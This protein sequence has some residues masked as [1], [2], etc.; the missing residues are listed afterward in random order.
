MRFYNIFVLP[1]LMF[2]AGTWAAPQSIMDSVDI[3]MRKQ[4]CL[5]LGV[6][7]PNHISND[8]LLKLTKQSALKGKIVQAR[9]RLLGHQLRLPMEVPF[10][11]AMKLVCDWLK[12][13]K[14]AQGRPKS[15][16]LTQWTSDLASMDAFKRFKLSFF[17]IWS[18]VVI[19]REVAF[20]RY[21][22]KQLVKK[23]VQACR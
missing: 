21:A 10:W 20:D 9:W 15:N 17:W 12:K 5:L 7:Y 11:V 2:N 8:D 22:W 19:I 23:I 1:V 13:A 3:K 18:D 4:L 14:K 6:Y 16:I